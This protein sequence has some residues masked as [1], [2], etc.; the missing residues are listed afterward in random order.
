MGKKKEPFELPYQERPKKPNKHALKVSLPPDLLHEARN[1]VGYLLS[2]R[3][4]GDITPLPTIAGL[5]EAGIRR[6]VERLKREHM[7]G[8]SF[9]VYKKELPRG[10]PEGSIK[11]IDGKA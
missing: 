7:K 6:E 2:I 1:A 5:F 4:A 8:E 11:L 10:R 9:P 3:K